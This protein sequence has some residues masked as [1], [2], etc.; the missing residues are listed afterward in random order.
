MTNNL[1]ATLRHFRDNSN[2]YPFIRSY[3]PLYMDEPP[4]EDFLHAYY[5]FFEC[6]RCV[7]RLES[8]LRLLLKLSGQER[9]LMTAMFRHSITSNNWGHETHVSALHH[10]HDLYEMR[11][12]LTDLVNA[13]IRNKNYIHVIGL[14][15][16]LK[17]YKVSFDREAFEADVFNTKSRYLIHNMLQYANA[18]FPDTYKQICAKYFDYPDYDTR[19]A[20]YLGFFNVYNE[21]ADYFCIKRNLDYESN[22]LKDDG[23][24]A[25][26]LGCEPYLSEEIFAD[27]ELFAI[28]KQELLHLLTMKL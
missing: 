16:F 10:M 28:K 3:L 8:D 19:K 24:Y 2:K 5:D 11:F 22:W 4:S 7:E 9:K 15:G 26:K 12:F 25:G 6:Y 27:K 17:K 14:S 13:D 18:V 20:A 1:T 23:S 21:C